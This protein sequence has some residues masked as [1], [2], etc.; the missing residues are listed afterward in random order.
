MATNTRT[1]VTITRLERAPDGWWELAW[2]AA[3]DD[4]DAIVQA[5]KSLPLDRRRYDP[6]RRL[7]RIASTSLLLGLGVYLGPD[8]AQRVERLLGKE[9]PR[10]SVL[11]LPQTVE[12]AFTRLYLLP[13]A[14]RSVV[15]AVYRALAAE[16][17]PDVGGSTADMQR[18]N[19]AR[20]TA[21]AWLESHPR[22]TRAA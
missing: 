5:V 2:R 14:P 4:F 15:K 7:W 20:D 11:A 18:L 13:T 3:P 10:P 1:P 22:R 12:A 17:H 16:T 6:Q 9:E 21:M 19:A 8:L